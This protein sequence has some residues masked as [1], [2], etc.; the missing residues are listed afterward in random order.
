[1]VAALQVRNTEIPVASLI[2][3]DAVLRAAHIKASVMFPTE[4]RGP[5]VLIGGAT[6]LLVVTLFLGPLSDATTRSLTSSAGAG[7]ASSANRMADRQPSSAAGTGVQLRPIPELAPR[8]G[9]GERQST[10]TVD[11]DPRNPISARTPRTPYGGNT[12]EAAETLGTRQAASSAGPSIDPAPGSVAITADVGRAAGREG[13]VSSSQDRGGVPGSAGAD[14]SGLGQG[15]G[16]GGVSRGSLM[17]DFTEPPASRRR[18]SQRS[19]SR[20]QAIQGAEAAISRDDVPPDLRSYVR[21][22]LH[23]IAPVSESK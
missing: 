5:I 13:N 21:E 10:S 18:A 3:R 16:A 2:I 15:S 19:S 4:L 14:A 8:S 11:S 12:S 1:V 17:R 23:A 6:L 7:N 20:A 22:Y 9:D